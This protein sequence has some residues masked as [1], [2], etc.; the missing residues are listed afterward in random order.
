MKLKDVPLGM[1]FRFVDWRITPQRPNR[2]IYIHSGNGW[3]CTPTRYDG[4]PW[5]AEVSSDVEML[6]GRLHTFSFSG[7]DDAEFMA[8]LPS[9]TEQGDFALFLS[10]CTERGLI[11]PAT[12]R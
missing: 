12:L 4:G 5:H 8:C 6:P 10:E 11:P 3:Y 2:P 1:P 9:I 7:L